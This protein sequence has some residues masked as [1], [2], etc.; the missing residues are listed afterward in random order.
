MASVIPFQIST[1]VPVPHMQADPD[2]YVG[3][4]AY[5]LATVDDPLVN[6]FPGDWIVTTGSTTPSVPTYWG[7]IAGGGVTTRTYT[8][9]SATEYSS[10]F[11]TTLNRGTSSSSVVPDPDSYWMPQAD[12]PT[13]Y[14]T[15]VPA[16][17]L[18][19]RS[20]RFPNI[21]YLQYVRTGIIPDDESL[22]YNP[23]GLSRSQYQHE[24]RS[25]F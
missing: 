19:P 9:N 15:N 14:L 1:P 10:G 13:C 11:H 2:A 23:V 22:P 18:I 25:A 5:V 16:Q 24:H 21:G 6:K 8:V 17:T 20:A 7:S 12:V 3:S 4:P